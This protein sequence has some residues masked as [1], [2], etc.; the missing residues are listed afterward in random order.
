MLELGFAPCTC[1]ASVLLLIVANTLAAIERGAQGKQ[2]VAL[3]IRGAGCCLWFSNQVFS[4]EM[5]DRFPAKCLV[6][7]DAA[8]AEQ[9]ELSPL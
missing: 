7:H 9:A 6:P 4:Q 8:V 5:Q 1:T 3:K 2:Y